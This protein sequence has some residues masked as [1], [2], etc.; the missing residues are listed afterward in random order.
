MKILITGHKG[1]VGR[2]F[3]EKYKT[4]DITGVDI[5]DGND[6]RNFFKT[7]SEKFDLVIHLAAVVGGRETI[8]KSPIL[9]A[10]DLSIDSEL[11]KWV[12]RTRPERLVYFSSS[13]AYPIK[14]QTKDQQRRLSENLIDLKM[15]SN[16]DMTYGWAKLTGEYL[17]SFID[18]RITKVHIF[19]PF[20]GYGSD[21][22][23]DYPFSSFVHRAKNK[24]KKFEV[25]GDGT[26]VRDWIH[27][28]DIVDSVDAAISYEITIPINL[29]SSIPVSFNELA[30][31]V[32][33]VAGISPEIVHLHN[34]PKGVHYRVSD[35][36]RLRTFYKPKISL[37]DGIDMAL[38]N[39]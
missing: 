31:A 21:Q 33:K 5:V 39:V 10:T 8:E 20:S 14:Y 28:Q 13:A 3:T 32:T 15:I 37:E 19:R 38:R 27:I 30:S 24:V 25:W 22:S 12:E 17:C 6:V 36:S 2:Y 29:G 26:Q 9:V 16:P 35:N 4:H 23:L 7:N 34:K 11:V 1:F 18:Q